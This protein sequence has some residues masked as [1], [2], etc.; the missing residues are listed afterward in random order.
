M[1]QIIVCASGVGLG[2][3]KSSPQS[4]DRVVRS[5]QSLFMHGMYVL[6]LDTGTPVALGCNLGVSGRALAFAPA[7]TVVADSQRRRRHCCSF[8]RSFLCLFFLI[9]VRGW[10]DGHP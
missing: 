9:K 6:T 3:I 10:P 1:Q 5:T 7:F 4:C 8:V 2:I